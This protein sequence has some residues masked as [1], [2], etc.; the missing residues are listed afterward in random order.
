MLGSSGYT[1]PRHLQ[2]ELTLWF[3]FPRSKFIALPDHCCLVVYRTCDHGLY[4]SRNH[5]DCYC[6]KGLLHLEKS[7]DRAF[8]Q[9]VPACSSLT[10]STSSNKIWY[11]ANIYINLAINQSKNLKHG[12][13]R[14][15]QFQVW[16]VWLGLTPSFLLFGCGF[17]WPLCALTN[18]TYILT[19]LVIKQIL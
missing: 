15:V 16:K 19:C 13:R 6:V 11:L 1:S 10:T 8:C 5:K 12:V 17:C 18:Y 4:I 7:W 2:Q 14:Q 3:L 9:A